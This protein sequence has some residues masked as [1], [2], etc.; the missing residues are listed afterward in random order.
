MI[1]QLRYCVELLDARCSEEVRTDL[2]SAVGFFAHTAGFMAF[3]AGVQDDA[4]RMFRFSLGCAEEL[5]DWHLRAKALSSMGKQAIRYGDP[6]AALTSIELA[7][8]RAERL[9][10]TERAILHTLRAHAFGKLGR[11]QEAARVVGLADEEFSHAR[12]SDDP[13]ASVRHYNDTRHAGETGRALWNIAVH[14]GL[15]VGAT[16]VPV[17]SFS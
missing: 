3:D 8:V 11:V 10:H 14:H 15:F 5:G 2:F 16:D 6:D 9:T 1:A 17:G 7:M 12:P 4:Q 13:T